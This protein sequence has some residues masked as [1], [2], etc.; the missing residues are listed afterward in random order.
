MNRFF[1]NVAYHLLKRLSHE[2]NKQTN[3]QISAIAE[4]E[5]YNPTEAHTFLSYTQQYADYH[6]KTVLDVGCGTGDLAITLAKSG[7]GRVVGV[8]VDAERIVTARRKATVAEV[9]HLV[10]FEATDFTNNYQPD[11]PFDII[12][13]KDTF[14]H[15]PD[16]LTCLQK[17]HTC[18]VPQG[19]FVTLFG[20]LWLSPYGAHMVG[21]TRLPWVHLLFPER[22]VL[23][24]RRDYFRPDEPATRYEDIRGHLNRMTVR[25]FKQHAH[26]ANFS[27]Q[28]IRLNPPQDRGKYK[29][30][31]AL[32]NSIPLLHEPASLL[33]LAVLEKSKTL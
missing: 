18:L 12:Y 25:R 11:M 24:V 13:S 3:Q 23:Q 4:Q 32:I 17:I 16:P 21:F 10:T 20:P 15:I 7:A 31:N 29:A 8:D 26:A 2:R 14:E 30:L 1:D 9:E 33:L 19:L 22:T 27:P 28:L 6:G 5:A